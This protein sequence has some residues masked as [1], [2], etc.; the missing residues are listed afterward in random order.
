MGVGALVLGVH[1]LS[2]APQSEFA[3]RAREALTAL[4]PAPAGNPTP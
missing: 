4:P 3:L 1:A 2:Q